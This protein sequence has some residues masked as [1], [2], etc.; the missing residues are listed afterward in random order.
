MKLDG[1]PLGQ[2]SFQMCSSDEAFRVT[3]LSRHL[4]AQRT[5]FK[6]LLA[7]SDL[8]VLHWINLNRHHIELTTLT[9]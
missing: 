1:R 4:H 2:Q 5:N 6:K 7:L 9:R 3:T 8:K